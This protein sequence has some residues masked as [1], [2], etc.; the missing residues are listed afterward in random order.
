MAWADAGQGAAAMPVVR[1][2]CG[3]AVS[4]RSAVSTPATATCRCRYQSLT[5]SG[6][7]Y[8]QV[9]TKCTILEGRHFLTPEV[10]RHTLTDLLDCDRR[11]VL[12]HRKPSTISTQRQH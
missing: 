1:I 6:M 10:K 8:D 7:I 9:S 4:N 2:G 5:A 11:E 12:P 3:F